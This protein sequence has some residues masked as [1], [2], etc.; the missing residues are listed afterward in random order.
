MQGSH[1]LAIPMAKAAGERSQLSTAGVVHGQSL[2]GEH[3]AHRA[4]RPH[5]GWPFDPGG[6]PGA[7][8]AEFGWSLRAAWG[9]ANG[10]GVYS[11]AVTWA[12]RV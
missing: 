12:G 5:H 2:Q 3:P 6:G 7:G 11:A 4:R 1:T 9:V 8:G 10:Q